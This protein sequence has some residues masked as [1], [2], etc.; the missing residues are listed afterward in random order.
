MYKD[1]NLVITLS[2]CFFLTEAL[3]QCCDD[4]PVNRTNLQVVSPHQPSPQRVR[5]QLPKDLSQLKEQHLTSP[6]RIVYVLPVEAGSEMRWGDAFKECLKHKIADSHDAILVFPELAQLPW[7]ADHPTDNKIAQESFFLKSVIP[8]VDEQLNLSDNNVERYL[9]GFSKSGWGAFSLLLRHPDVFQRA[10]AWDAPLMIDEPGKYGSGPIF[11]TQ[12]NFQ[13][14]HISKL[15]A[16]KA[17]H[18]RANTRL[19]SLGYD[20]FRKHHLQ[21]HE[22][23]DRLKISHIHQDGPQRK[24]HWNSGWLPE[25]VDFLLTDPAQ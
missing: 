13:S 3:A 24:H 22:L 19:I 15:L 14:Y 4:L 17:K 16:E 10:A 12:E 5:L 21:F 11:G 1:I 9:L 7:Y 25:A 23:A 6:I 8:Q 18:F 2:L 20:N